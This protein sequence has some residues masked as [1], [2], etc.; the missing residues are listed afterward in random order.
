MLV[1]HNT[2]GSIATGF[3]CECTSRLSAR[4]SEEDAIA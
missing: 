3:V 4:V 1:D 2:G